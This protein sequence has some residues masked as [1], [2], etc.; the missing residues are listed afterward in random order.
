MSQDP[1]RTRSVV[2]FEYE[3]RLP[4][5]T[6]TK[7]PSIGKFRIVGVVAFGEK[8]PISYDNCCEEFGL[9]GKALCFDLGDSDGV[10]HN[11]RRSLLSKQR[12]LVLAQQ[13]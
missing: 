1:T 4:L 5:S 10:L 7:M 9:R 3:Y 6:S 2:I 8:S 12:R 13:R 11:P